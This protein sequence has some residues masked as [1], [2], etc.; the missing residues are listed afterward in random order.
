MNRFL[1]YYLYFGIISISSVAV[2]QD[3]FEAYKRE[4]EQGVTQIKEEFRKFKDENDRQF[5]DF[6]KAQWR[7]FETRKGVIR[8]LKPKP[9]VVPVA[10]PVVQEKPVPRPKPIITTPSVP[11][12]PQE[13]PKPVL[14]PAPLPLPV[15]PIS[16]R[17]SEGATVQVNFYGNTVA[18]PYLSAWKQRLVSG[19]LSAEVMSN[20][21]VAIGTS[22]FEPT[23]GYLRQFQ[24]TMKLDDWG[25]FSLLRAYAKNLQPNS[26]TDQNL[27]LWFFMIKSGYDVRCAYMGSE[28]YVFIA[29]SQQV[30][31]TK[32]MDV[33]DTPYYALL[34]ADRGDSMKSYY[35]YDAKYPGNLRALDLRVRSLAFTQPSVVARELKWEYAG[36]KYRIAATYDRRAIDFLSSYPQADIKVHFSSTLSPVSRTTLL[37][38]LQPL[39]AG[40]GEEQAVN[41]LLAFVQ[42]AFEYKTDEDQFGREKYF[43]GEELFFY[44]Y[45]DCED[46]SVFFALLVKDLVGLDVVGL[47]YPGHIATAVKF[48]AATP[49]G[50]AVSVN[51]ARYVV[52]DPTYIGAPLGMAQPAYLKTVPKVINW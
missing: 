29:V 46:R 44:P 42:R 50:D 26:V 40:M 38:E 41:F 13:L 8:D 34:A 2:T 47:S 17:V 14:V 4:Q 37:R 51:G 9:K 7:E 21:W 52:A 1:L 12:K 23:L 25:Y 5:A 16:P 31:G 24:N 22:N 30:Y 48:K 18:V 28:L 35:T 3:D 36:K 32:Y 43:F 6:L 49:R 10:K 20:F 11:E 27:L 15:L 33:K 19:N 39:I 45:S